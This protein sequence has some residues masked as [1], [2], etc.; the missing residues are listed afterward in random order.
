MTTIRRIAVLGA[1]TMGSRIA[2]H[3]ANAGY[4]ALLLDIVAAGAPQR[5]AAA[6]KGIESAKKQSPG[7]FFTDAAA[8]LVTAGNFEDDLGRVAECDWIIE[9]VTE[10]LAIKRA[11]YEKVAA[12]RRMGTIVSTN[13]SGIPLAQIAEGW[14]EEMR[15]HFLGTHFFNPPRYLHLLELISGADSDP[16]VL[17]AVGDFCDRQL[18]KGVVPCKDTPNFIANRIG[19]F[20]GATI[21]KIMMEDGYTVEEVDAI[22]GPLI[23]LPNSASFRLLDIVG[24]DVWNFVSKNLYEL[25]PNDPWRERF[26]PPP[27]LTEMVSRGWLGEKSGQGFFK[28]LGKG[29]KKEIHAIDWKTYEYHPAQKVNLPEAEQARM[30]EDLPA[31]LKALVYGKGRVANFLWKLY[32]DGFLYTAERMP[33]ISDRIV[34][35]DRA[36]RWGYAHKLGPFELADALGVEEMARRIEAEGRALPAAVVKMLA[37]GAKGFYRPA[38]SNGV[39][40]D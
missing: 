15:R 7:G 29:D 37:T 5:N 20:F 1:G 2:A 38:D 17:A 19:S 9:A 39:P 34:E 33:E 31:R 13:T 6:L 23:G 4:P 3:F 35:V 22:T 40:Q 28:R 32:S 11:L 36:M 25:V 30:I 24:L 16:A 18:G 21:H 27:F 26:V 14:P 10:N 12:V 8:G